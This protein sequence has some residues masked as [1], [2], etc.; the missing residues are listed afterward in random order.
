MDPAAFNNPIVQNAYAL[1]AKV[2]RV[3]YQEPCFC[4][5]DRGFGHESLLDATSAS[6]PR[7]AMFA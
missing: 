5:C 3:L 1:A 7:F 4:H 6:M 2:K